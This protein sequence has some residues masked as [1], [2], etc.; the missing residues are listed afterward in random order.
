MQT[1]GTV[2]D[3]TEGHT[4]GEVARLT[5]VSA[6]AIRYYEAR[7]LLPAPPRGANAY[8]RYGQAEVN[9]LILLR[10]I[11]LLG[12][13]LAVARP[14][15]A[16]ATDARCADVQRELT[17]LVARRLRAIDQEVAELLTLRQDLANYQRRLEACQKESDQSDMAF[18]ACRDVSCLTLACEGETCDDC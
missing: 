16:G 3:R 17:A 4:I 14:L 10:R 5:G 15:L 7:G 18:S 8:R 9:R 2:R 12:V 1:S 6:K 11:R 13:P